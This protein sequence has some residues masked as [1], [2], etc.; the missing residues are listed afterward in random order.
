M[1]MSQ[2]LAT[3]TLSPIPCNCTHSVLRCRG[4]RH[5]LMLKKKKKIINTH[6]PTTYEEHPHRHQQ[7]QQH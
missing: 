2:T 1:M 6:K 3:V 4:T 5:L 7:Q